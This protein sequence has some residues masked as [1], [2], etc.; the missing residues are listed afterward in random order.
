MSMHVDDLRKLR[1]QSVRKRR[2]PVRDLA[3]PSER[4]SAQDL[5][6]L[7]LKLQTTIEAI[8]RALA[9][10]QADAAQSWQLDASRESAA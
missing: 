7:F 5:R 10:E 2:Q 3:N 9:G 8:D 4:D 6:D 1:S